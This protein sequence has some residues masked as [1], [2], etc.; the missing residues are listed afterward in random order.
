MIPLL[1]KVAGAW[2]RI[3][4]NHRLPVKVPQP[5]PVPVTDAHRK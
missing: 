2:G 4:P 5:I 1:I 3:V